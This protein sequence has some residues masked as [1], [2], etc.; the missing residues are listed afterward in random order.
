MEA[1]WLNFHNKFNLVLDSIRS[2]I[3]LHNKTLLLKIIVGLYF[4]SLVGSIFSSVTTL[5]I[6]KFY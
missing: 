5:V 6:S 2:A 3:L 4:A 1:N